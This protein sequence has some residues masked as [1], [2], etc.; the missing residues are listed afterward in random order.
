MA[1][2]LLWRHL[3]QRHFSVPD[4]AAP[5]SWKELYKCAHSLAGAMLGRVPACRCWC[6]THRAVQP[7]K[8]EQLPRLTRPSRPNTPACRFNHSLFRELFLQGCRDQVNAHLAGPVQVPTAA[9][10]F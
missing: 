2:D 7:P 9:F 5:E 6:C 4:Y 10:G 3:C 1:D 8:C